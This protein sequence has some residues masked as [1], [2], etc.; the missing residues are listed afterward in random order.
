MGY[1]AESE[2]ARFSELCERRQRSMAQPPWT[3][4][5]WGT[6]TDSELLY[7]LLVAS[8]NVPEAHGD[9]FLRFHQVTAELRAQA[10]AEARSDDGTTHRQTV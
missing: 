9:L 3:R 6:A 1:L 8:L 4:H 5:S 2:L 10:A 7:G